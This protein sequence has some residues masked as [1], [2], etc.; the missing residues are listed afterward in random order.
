MGKINSQ[1]GPNWFQTL[2][3]R[4]AGSVFVKQFNKVLACRR[5]LNLIKCSRIKITVCKEEPL[6]DNK[7]RANKIQLMELKGM[8]ICK[9]MATKAIMAR[10]LR[11]QQQSWSLKMRWQYNSKINSIK[12]FIIIKTRTS[13]KSCYTSRFP[14]WRS[15]LRISLRIL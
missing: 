3:N 5:A 6:L 8:T 2:I 14:N 12:T 13:A 15:K 7:T 11:R 1:T 9:P 10:R 4:E